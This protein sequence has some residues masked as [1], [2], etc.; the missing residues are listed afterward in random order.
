MVRRTAQERFRIVSTPSECYSTNMK[1]TKHT[2]IALQK[3]ITRAGMTLIAIGCTANL[4]SI[5]VNTR[6]VHDP[7]DYLYY[8]R[9]IILLLGGF[10]IGY[11]LAKR[12]KREDRLFIG[13]GYALLA[14]T[15]FWLLDL[16][17]LAFQH[18]FSA[19]PY[20]WGRI[21]FMGTPLVS[22]LLT[23]ATAY[24]TQRKIKSSQ[25]STPT[26]KLVIFSFVL[27]QLYAI[28][29]SSSLLLTNTVTGGQ[30][31]FGW[32]LTSISYLLAPLAVAIVAYLLVAAKPPLDRFFYAALIGTFYSTLSIVLWEFRTD[33]TYDAT[34]MF[35]VGVVAVSVLFA[36]VIIWKARRAI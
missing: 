17:R 13:V 6:F 31:L 21:L 12:S 20:P 3:L 10:A 9:F 25:L 22:L 11:F 19:Q 33:A 5:V 2:N 28:L 27:Y 23:L 16:A 26:K 32:F 34:T 30:N 18:I 14:Q 24:L 36:S 29:E 4:Y 7:L 35:S 1:T 15:L 8:L